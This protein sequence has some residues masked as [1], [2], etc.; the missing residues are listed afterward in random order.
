[1]EKRYNIVHLICAMVFGAAITLAIGLGSHVL[2]TSSD[3]SRMASEMARY[4]R[5]EA[6]AP[7]CA[8]KFN[9]DAAAS[10]DELKKISSRWEQGEFIARGGWAILPG[11]GQYPFAGVAHR[12]A[13]L[14]TNPP[15]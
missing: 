10:L 3:A 12:C 4:A 2:T 13:V 1:M 11:T 14:L 6:L 7:I 15:G 9:K 5:E 8:D